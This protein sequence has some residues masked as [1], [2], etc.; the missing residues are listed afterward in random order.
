MVSIFID[1]I[2]L[3]FGTISV[4]ET[5]QAK[6]LQ[7]VITDVKIWSSAS[8]QEKK[9]GADGVYHFYP[10][11]SYQYKLN[12]DLSAYNGNLADDLVT[13]TIPCANSS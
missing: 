1:A 9:P 12:F 2:I 13:F 8:G 3:F 11:N 10:N 6:E 4:S 7:N 5:V